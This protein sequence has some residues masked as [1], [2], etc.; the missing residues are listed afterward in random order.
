MFVWKQ[1]PREC[2]VYLSEFKHCKSLW[3][4]FHE[5]YTYGKAPDCQRW[6]ED[7]TSCKEWEK[8]NSSHFRVNVHIALQLILAIYTGR[9]YLNQLSNNQA[10][11]TKYLFHI[12]CVCSSGSSSGQRE[13]ACGRTEKVLSR[14]G[15]S[16]DS[17]SRLAPATQPGQTT[18]LLNT[19]CTDHTR[20]LRIVLYSI[21]PWR[22]KSLELSDDDQ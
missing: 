9:E 21:N 16:A 12:F 10:L 15:A 13:E 6:K 20:L 3:N 17:S 18:G 7:Y 5:Y 1:P 2:D 4:R 8:N 22:K 11:A 14:L 19:H